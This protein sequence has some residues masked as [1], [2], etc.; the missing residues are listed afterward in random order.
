MSAP[1]R[2]WVAVVGAGPGALIVGDVRRGAS[3]LAAS[4]PGVEFAA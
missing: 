1:A 2:A 4:P 3:A